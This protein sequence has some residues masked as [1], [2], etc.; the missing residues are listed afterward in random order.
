MLLEEHTLTMLSRCGE[1]KYDITPCLLSLIINSCGSRPVETLYAS[2][3]S[4]NDII[5]VDLHE[6]QGEMTTARIC[7]EGQAYRT[8]GTEATD[9]GYTDVGKCNLHVDWHTY[10]MGLSHCH[11]GENH[12]AFLFQ[13]HCILCYNKTCSDNLAHTRIFQGRQA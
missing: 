8:I 11:L 9:R 2:L 12:V 4:A 7:S 3:T 5:S 1:E 13:R 6:R 10:V